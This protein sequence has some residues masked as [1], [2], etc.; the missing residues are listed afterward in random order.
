[1]NYDHAGT[2]IHFYDCSDYIAYP[3]D[4]DDY[5]LSDLLAFDDHSQY[6]CLQYKAAMESAQ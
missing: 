2:E 6:R 4:E 1:M 3:Y 5:P